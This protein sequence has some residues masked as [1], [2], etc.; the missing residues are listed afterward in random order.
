MKKERK[1]MFMFISLYETRTIKTGDKRSDGKKGTT[2]PPL[3]PQ[4]RP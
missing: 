1:Y 3:R 4:P 2:P